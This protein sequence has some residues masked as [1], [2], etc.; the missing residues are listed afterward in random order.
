MN[1]HW[2]YL[3]L[4]FVV[5]LQAQV[6]LSY[7]LAEDHPYDPSIPTPQSVLG[8]EVGNWHVSHDRLI[9]YMRALADASDRIQLT[10]R[11]YTYEQRPI[12]LLTITSPNNHSK[13]DQIQADHALLTSAAA[14]QLDLSKM[15][16]VVYQGFS[17]HGNEP[18]GSN[19]SLLAAYHLA[20]STAQETTALLENVVI[21]FDP[22]FNPDGL[23]RFAYWANTN[24]SSNLNPDNN[25]REYREVWPGGRTN[26]YWFDLNRDWLPSQLPESQ[27]RI[28]TFTNWLP[29]ILTDH[30]EMGTN[31]TFFFQPGIQSR[32][33]PLTP[34]KNQMLTQEIGTYHA[35]AFDDLGSLYY[36]E[37]DYDDF[38]YGK[39]S[40]Y[41]DVNGS[42]GI[43]FEQASSRGHVQNSDN[44]VLTFPFTVRN[45][46]TAAFSTL[47]AAYN[48][49]EKLL[50][51]MK[52][53][54]ANT[55]KAAG[56]SKQKALVFGNP[57]DPATAYELARVLHRHK[58]TTHQ[59]SKDTKIA[60]KNYPAA[61][62][63]VVPLNQP[64]NK[65][66]QAMFTIN[67]K[68]EDSLFYDISAWSF[69]HAFNQNL[70]YVN[71]TDMAGPKIEELEFPKGKVSAKAQYAYLFEA[72]SYY[73]PRAVQ[74]L[75]SAGIRVKTSLQAFTHKGKKY[76]YGTYMVPLQNQKLDADALYAL[77]QSLAAENALTITG[78]NGGQNAGIDMGSRN[79]VAVK[80]PKVA[81]LVGDGVRSYDAGEIWHLMDT[82]FN[83]P[84]TKIDTRNISRIDMTAYTH[85]IIPSFSGS[86][87]NSQ[88]EKLKAYVR[89]G[90]VIIGYRNTLNWLD[91][92]EFI[93]LDFKSTS[94][95]AKNIA[96]DQRRKF[97]GAEEIGGAIF[98]TKIDRSH[99][100]NFGI[101][102]NELPVFKNTRLFLSAD[103][104]SYNNPIQYTNSPLLNGYISKENLAVLKNTSY[105][106]SARMGRGKVIAFTDN[107][108]F[109]AF[110]YGTNRL[111]TNAIF[112]SNLF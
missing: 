60:G 12:V 71:T 62:S 1:K 46:L 97:R 56:R 93:D 67:K 44:G 100:I 64:K 30:H 51:Y 63:Y 87:L 61:S 26:H 88:V 74:R 106:K 14:E 101:H 95:D 40:T 23:Q 108:N 53:F 22:S 15:P 110:W 18:S 47:K 32:V 58:I 75:L 96:F 48:M 73:A 6:N 83:I 37:E 77:M 94:R 39:G 92:N 7:Y 20:A 76:D 28:K 65:L 104:N 81:L 25:D 50:R 70:S 21:L 9:Q 90:G 17:I 78:T 105:F 19:A 85:F 72:H 84:V 107:T 49:R 38:Y 4:L 29:N 82:R 16:L 42:I 33:N 80:T 36:S 31:S 109:R 35:A 45:Q 79:F 11:G 86:E 66:I 111:L 112:H 10:T 34:K 68:F 54:Y 5:P 99:P 8:Y 52:D 98:N 41:P 57:K 89:Q 102:S 24:R 43:L 3:L 27:A 2:L 103:K 91:R 59:L 55:R 69:Q 13:I